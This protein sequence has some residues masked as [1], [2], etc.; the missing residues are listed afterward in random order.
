MP[1]TIPTIPAGEIAAMKEKEYWEIAFEVMERFLRKEVPDEK[2]REICRD[3]YDFPVPVERVFDRNYVLRL[4]RG[5]TASFKDFAARM[6]SRLMQFFLK[7]E[8]KKLIILTATSGDTGSAVANAFLGQK[9][10]K[11]V[12]LFPEKEISERQRKQM[13]TLHGNVTVIGVDGKFDDCQAIVKQAFVDPELKEMN[14]SSANSIS[15]GRFLPQAAYYFY[16]YSKTFEYLGEKVVFAAPSGNFG[17]FTG[18]LIAERMGLPV[19]K[20]VVAVNEN[21]EFPRFMETGKYEKVVPSRQCLSN[22]MNVG[23]PSNLARVIELYS[24]RMDETGKIIRQPDLQRMR[25]EI[26]SVSV[27]DDQTRHAIKEAYKQYNTIFEPHGAVAWFALQRYL[28]RQESGACISIETAHPAKFPETI[29]ET[30][31]VDP[32]LHPSLAGLEGRKEKFEKMPNNYEQVKQFLLENSE[33][34]NR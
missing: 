19:K 26:F 6:M 25:E 20:F 14:L 8:E 9:N 22:A 34:V 4:D 17:N 10:I 1:E 5:P 3:A 16:G 31:A 21:D 2:L 15:L 28:E 7:Q 32:E 13:T 23:H 12:V 24:G 30:I 33:A 27:S 11:M 18:G 29:K